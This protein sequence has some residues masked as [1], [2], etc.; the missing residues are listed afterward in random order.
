MSILAQILEQM[1]VEPEILD[2][3]PDEQKEVLFRKMREEQVRR[4]AAREKEERSPPRR[5]APRKVG[6]EEA[7]QNSTVLY[8]QCVWYDNLTA[9]TRFHCMVALSQSRTEKLQLHHR[10][11]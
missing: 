2:L 3:L 1:Y 4:W 8:C 7:L 10:D 11:A 9:V 6:G 5:R